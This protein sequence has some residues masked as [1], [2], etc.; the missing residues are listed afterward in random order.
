MENLL[1]LDEAY[2]V[3]CRNSPKFAVRVLEKR[4]IGKNP[5]LADYQRALPILH[6]YRRM[7]PND[8]QRVAEVEREMKAIV[9]F[10]R[11]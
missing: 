2:G 5:T 4:L 3:F 10:A 8:V 7:Y 11:D 6:L 1:T 9:K